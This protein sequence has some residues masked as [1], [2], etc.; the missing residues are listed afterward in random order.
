[1]QFELAEMRRMLAEKEK[2]LQEAT[3]INQVYPDREASDDT[4]TLE[5]SLAAV[6]E[7]LAQKEVEVNDM[8]GLLEEAQEE[9]LEKEAE[10]VELERLLKEKD[11]KLT[12]KCL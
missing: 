8:A 5:E 9:F 7:E 3:R 4:V 12:Q 1:M 2:D 11:E 10:K 6:K